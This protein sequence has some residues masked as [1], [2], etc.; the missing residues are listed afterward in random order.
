[1]E[2]PHSESYSYRQIEW[3]EGDEDRIIY[4]MDYATAVVRLSSFAFHQ[5]GHQ[6]SSRGSSSGSP[7]E[8]E[9]FNLE[10]NIAHHI[11]HIDDW[12]R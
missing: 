3:E 5:E 7:W 2:P 11:G 4:M 1:V 6:A 10:K 12:D 8:K 9:D